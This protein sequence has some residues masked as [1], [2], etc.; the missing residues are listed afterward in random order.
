MYLLKVWRLWSGSALFSHYHVM[1]F[2][3][4]VALRDT[5]CMFSFLSSCVYKITGDWNVWVLCLRPFSESHGNS[6]IIC[7]GKTKVKVLR[8]N[9]QCQFQQNTNKMYHTKYQRLWWDIKHVSG[10]WW[11]RLVIYS[12]SCS[13]KYEFISSVDTNCD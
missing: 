3:Q 12:P 8:H 9:A 5:Q 11:C 7:T 13:Y 4:N 1:L 6:H 10:G 2:C